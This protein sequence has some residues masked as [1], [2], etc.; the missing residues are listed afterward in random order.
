MWISNSHIGKLT[1][2]YIIKNA[3]EWNISKVLKDIPKI[4]I[5][6]N[7]NKKFLIILSSGAL[8]F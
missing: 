7:N 1:K 8:S 5:S 3:H 6:V 4:T 2:F